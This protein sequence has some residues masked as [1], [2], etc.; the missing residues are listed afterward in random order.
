MEEETGM[1]RKLWILL[2]LVT[3]IAMVWGGSV[4][5]ETSG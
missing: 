1:K 5:A 3:L 4:L 2:A